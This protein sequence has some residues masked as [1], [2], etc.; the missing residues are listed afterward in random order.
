MN[1]PVTV[2][3]CAASPPRL[4][5]AALDAADAGH[6][7][8]PLWPRTKTPA[9]KDWENVA[10]VD[11]GQIREWWAQLPY[12]IGI[13]CGPA[14]LLVVDLD[15]AKGSRAPKRW[16][17]AHHGRDVFARVAASFGERY[18]DTYTVSTP[19]GGLHLYFQ[20]PEPE[21]RSRVARW[22]HV[23]TRGAGGYVV[24]AGSRTR[25]GFYRPV[26]PAP[27][28][29]LPEWLRREL[30]PAPPPEPVELV[31]PNGRAG[32][33]AAAAVDGEC[34]A[35]AA[36][37]IG[38]RHTTLLRAAGRLGQLIG[39]GA[40]DEHTARAALH[41]AV[42]VHIGHDEFT[43]H[44]AETTIRDGLVWGMDRPRHLTVDRG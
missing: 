17:A 33:Y 6:T 4:M 19:S 18:P 21:L 12:N 25:H 40:L 36:A 10:T 23:D 34:A 42:A 14:K 22:W 20:A 16:D 15:D 7:I 24:A 13:A 30:T 2:R 43:S 1:S 5:R 35:V 38:Q 31:L 44:E 32:A 3:P 28:A 8:I 39:G 11:H 27:I 41:Q 9:V 37:A 29:Q 26:R